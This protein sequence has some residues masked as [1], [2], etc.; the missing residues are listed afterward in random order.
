M[1]LFMSLLATCAVGETL[2]RIERPG[3]R[4]LCNTWHCCVSN[5]VDFHAAS[6]T[7]WPASFIYIIWIFKL[8]FVMGCLFAF[9][10]DL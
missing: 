10:N 9:V 5:D 3:D 7:E 1:V 8:T 4:L 2:M 6:M